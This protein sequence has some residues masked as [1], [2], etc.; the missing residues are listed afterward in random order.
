MLIADKSIHQKLKREIEMLNDALTPA[1][2]DQTII[3]VRKLSTHC[4]SPEMN[5]EERAT[6]FVDWCVDVEEMR[7]PLPL[8][9]TAA[10]Q[11]RRSNN[12][13]MPTFGQLYEMVKKEHRGLTCLVERAVEVSEKIGA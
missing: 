5:E 9:E 6:W 3:T 1:T 13:F 7:L 11:W 10:K 2:D 4:R 12:P 8:L